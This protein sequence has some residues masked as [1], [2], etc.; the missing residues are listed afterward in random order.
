[1]SF[2]NPQLVRKPSLSDYI[3]QFDQIENETKFIEDP[4]VLS[5]SLKDLASR[6]EGFFSLNSNLVQ[7]NI[8]PEIREQAETIRSY[9]IKKYIWAGLKSDKGLSSFKSK[10]AQ[11]LTSRETRL[12]ETEVGLMVKL[13]WFYDEDM[14]Y[15]ELRSNYTPHPLANNPVPSYGKAHE[16]ELNFVHSNLRWRGNVRNQIYWFKD[17]ENH[18]YHIALDLKNPLLLFFVGFLTPRMKFESLLS[19]ST[20]GGIVSCKL[21]NYKLLKEPN[22]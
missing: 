17:S 12:T 5:C 11:L 13:P 18:L 20:I 15:N 19:P 21:Y 8:T 14:V 1:M 9:F 6:N 2:Q 7:T 16:L 22:A 3:V 4:L 10:T